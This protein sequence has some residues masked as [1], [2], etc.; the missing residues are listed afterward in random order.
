MPLRQLLASDQTFAD[1]GYR[2]HNEN[3][4]QRVSRNLRWFNQT[5]AVSRRPLEALTKHD[6][7]FCAKFLI[8]LSRLIVF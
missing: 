6:N 3:D 5:P 8:I 4:T 2:Q 7:A 1:D